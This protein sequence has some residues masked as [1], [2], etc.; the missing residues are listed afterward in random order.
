ME[1]GVAE[2]S[3]ALARHF[4]KAL[5]Q[6]FRLPHNQLRNDLVMKP[7]VE[8][9]ISQQKTAVQKRD[10]KFGIVRIEVVAFRDRPRRGTEFQFEV[11]QF[12]REAPHLLSMNFF[13]GAIGK[14]EQKVN[15]GIRE[16]P[17]AAETPGGRQGKTSGLLL[18]GGNK[19][20]PE[21]SKDVFD[22]EPALRNGG[23]ALP[24]GSKAQRN[25][26]RLVGERTSPFTDQ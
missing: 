4:R 9:L 11:P 25:P 21:S 2:F 22:Q 12:L 13:G 1:H 24:G 19:L 26:R 3:M 14:Q 7:G 15:V 23:P 17:A 20:V 8:L 16:E 6:S 18:V 5:Q 10:C